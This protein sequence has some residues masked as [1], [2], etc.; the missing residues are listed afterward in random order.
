MDGPVDV[1]DLQGFLVFIAKRWCPL[2]ACYG[3]LVGIK[4]SFIFSAPVHH[5]LKKRLLPSPRLRD[6]FLEA[7]ALHQPISILRLAITGK[8]QHRFWMN[9]SEHVNSQ[10]WISPQNKAPLTLGRAVMAMSS[11]AP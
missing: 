3:A 4:L 9:R 7:G 2:S 8:L 6:P 11:Q 5:D 1:V 10:R